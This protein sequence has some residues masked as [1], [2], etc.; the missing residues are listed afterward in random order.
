ML[1][2]GNSLLTS[3]LRDDTANDRCI[4][5]HAPIQEMYMDDLISHTRF[6]LSQKP[7]RPFLR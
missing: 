4:F 2:E 3:D 6:R 1:R 7:R 5:E